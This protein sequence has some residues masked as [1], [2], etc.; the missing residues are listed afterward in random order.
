MVHQLQVPPHPAFFFSSFIY[1]FFSSVT[2]SL[3]VAL[4]GLASLY[5]SAIQSS[6][7]CLLGT[8]ITGMNHCAWQPLSPLKQGFTQPRLVSN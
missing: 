6:Y 3:N 8:G 2:K 5:H 4:G 1:L 7:L